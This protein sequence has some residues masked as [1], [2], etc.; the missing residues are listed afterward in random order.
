MPPEVCQ[1]QNGHY[2][3]QGRASDIWALGLF[4]CL[5]SKRK[6]NKFFIFLLGVLLFEM[7]FGY[8]PFEHVR[9]NFDKMSHI[10]RLTQNPII[11]PINNP[12]IRDILQQCLQINPAHRPTAQELLQHPFFNF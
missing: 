12:H 1:I 9:D 8:R 10:A 6:Q 5:F 2:S 7:I 3:C 4:C 11:P